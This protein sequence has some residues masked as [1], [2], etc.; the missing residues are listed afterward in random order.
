MN[1]SQNTTKALLVVIAVLSGTIV[2]MVA[3]MLSRMDGKSVPDAL[4]I[5]GGAF[6]A[7]VGLLFGI[8]GFWYGS[9]NR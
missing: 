8:F 3:G 9:Q 7:A 2:G 4:Q 6:A 1:T 5:G